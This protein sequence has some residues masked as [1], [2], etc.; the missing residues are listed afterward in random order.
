[1]LFTL[2]QIPPLASG[3]L[4]W[5]RRFTD[6]AHNVIP[7]FLGCGNRGCDLSFVLG[8]VR[9][10]VPKAACISA[11]CRLPAHASLRS[12]VGYGVGAGGVVEWVG[13]RVNA[14]VGRCSYGSAI[15]R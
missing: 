5:L 14:G 10:P 8:D 7:R 15:R 4:D 11:E 2:S 12:R 3:T 6:V 13:C 9:G 1:M